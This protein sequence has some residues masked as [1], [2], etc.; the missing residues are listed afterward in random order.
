[1]NVLHL[2]SGRTFTGPAA[3]A[4]T[5]LRALQACGHQVWLA[6]RSGSHLEDGAKREGIPFAGGLRLDRGLARIATAPFD[7][8]KLRKICL[9]LKIDIVHVHR[10][11]DHLLARLAVGSGAH[12]KLVRSWHRD[13]G[14]SSPGTR[15]K[16]ARWAAGHLMASREHKDLLAEDTDLP[17][18]YLHPGTDTERYRP[19]EKQEGLRTLTV[20]LIGRWKRK[21]DRGQNAVLELCTRLDLRLPWRLVLLG[22]GERQPDLERAI[23]AHARK[24]RLSMEV[25]SDEYPR[26]AARLDLGLIFATGSDG[27]SRPALELLACGVPIALADLPGLRELGEDPGCARLVRP[28]DLTDWTKTIE[29]LIREPA[30]LAQMS[31]Q[32]RARAEAVHALPKRGKALA[33]FYAKL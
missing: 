19:I 30:N 23:A 21:E 13:P 8:R 27:A 18:Q 24:D 26:Q 12:A 6:S 17:V 16:L 28:K 5:D 33:D 31:R 10:S 29:E 15:G 32:A 11:S 25:T 7:A 20:G 22:R 4:L 14:Q 2:I 3:A 9:E 1:M